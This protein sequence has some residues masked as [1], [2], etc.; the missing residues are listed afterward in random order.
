LFNPFVPLFDAEAWLTGL[1]PYQ[2]DSA[3]LVLKDLLRLGAHASF[4]VEGGR[5]LVA[6]HRDVVP[7]R[8]VSDG[9]QSVVATAIDILEVVMRL[10]PNVADAEGIVLLDEIGA[11]LHP[12]WKMR[13][14]ESIRRALPGIQFVTSTH[15]PL[16]L[17]GLGAGEVVVMQ[18][19]EDEKLRH[20][21]DLPSP[22]D[23]RVDQLLTSDFFGLN[24]TVDPE[25]EALFDEYYAL[26]A[27]ADPSTA[28][29]DRLAELRVELKDRRHLGSTMR[30]SLMYEAVDRLLA[31]HKRNPQRSLP[32]LTH[33]AADEIARIWAEDQPGASTQ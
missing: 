4:L 20:L 9:Y 2:F 22:A 13:I 21:T 28:Q 30:E 11:H 16:C 8:Q 1:E 10:W 18:R 24:T 3:A 23:F 31:R 26:L 33:E 5:V 6:E 12:T 15:D 7:L 29:A 17:R 32:D 19:D 25:T 27:L 14:V